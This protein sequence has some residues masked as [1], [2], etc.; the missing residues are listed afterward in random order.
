[1]MAEAY[2]KGLPVALERGLV[3]MD[4]IDECVRR[5]LRLKERL[6]L[7]DDPYRRGSRAERRGGRRRRRAVA[8]DVAAKSLVLVKNFATR[9]PSASRRARLRD[10]AAGRRVARNARALGRCGRGRAR[11]TVLAGL[12]EA[13]PKRD[14]VHAKASRS[15]AIAA[16]SRRPSTLG[17]RCRCRRSVPRRSG[18]MSGEAS[19]RATP[20]C[21]ASNALAEAVLDRA[22]ANQ[23][24]SWSCCSAAGR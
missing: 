19:S 4:E 21:P 14:I 11:F 16:A 12:R 2:R 17:G 6:G 3:T 7:F 22:R 13:L 18:R 15:P 5:V 10:R 8:R 9:C 20:S 24:P 23:M 1:M